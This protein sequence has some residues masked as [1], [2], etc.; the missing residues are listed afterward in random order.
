[1]QP[2]S[3]RLLLGDCLTMMDEIEGSTI[4]LILCDLPYGTTACK[5]DS[6]IPLEP[7]WAQYQR[8]LKPRGVVVLTA[9]QPFTTTLVASNRKWF[10]YEDVWDKIGTTGYLDA[11]RRPLRR[12]E[13]ILIFSPRGRTTYNPQM[14]QGKAYCFKRGGGASIYR[15]HERVWSRN[16]GTRYPT[17]IVSISNANG[18]R[19]GKVH[20]TQKPVELGRYLIRTYSNPGDAVLDNA[21]GVGSF[22]VA[23][24]MEGRSFTGIEKDPGYFALAEQRLA[25]P[26]SEPERVT[27]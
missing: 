3:H 13:S 14:G 19:I 12:H 27:A 24:L 11:N 17:S 6:V 8:V 18:L 23:A 21:M 4:D 5:W 2:M 16:E 15:Q 26:V 20:P 22:G 25:T 7:L 1:M 10:R 9:S